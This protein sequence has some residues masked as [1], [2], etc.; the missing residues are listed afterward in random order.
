VLVLLFY[1][2]TLY[3]VAQNKTE[4]N[5]KQHLQFDTHFI[6]GNKFLMLKQPDDALREFKMALSIFPEEAAVNYLISQIYLQK[7]LLLDAELYAEK[8]AKT[9]PINEWYYKLLAEIY[10]QQKKYT[11]A[12]KLYENLFTTDY[13]N[14]AF[15]FDA[16]YLYMLAQNFSP[17]IGLLQ[18]AEKKNGINADISKQIISIY[19][20]QGNTKK[21]ITEANKLVQKFPKSMEYLGQLADLY[22]KAGNEKEAN[23]IYTNILTIEPDNGYALLAM[24]DYYRNSKQFELWYA[25]TLNA[26]KST[27]LDIKSKLRAIVNVMADKELS[28]EQSSKAIDFANAFTQAN[29]DEQTAWMILG[30]IYFEKRDVVNAHIQYEK[31]AEINPSNYSVW[32]QMIICSSELNNHEWIMHDCGRALEIFPTDAALYAYYTF[33]AMQLKQYEKAIDV[34]Q[35][36]IENVMPDTALLIQL[37]I[38]IGDAA[39]YLEKFTT[40]DSAFEAA[41]TLNPNSVYA[42]NNYA[43]FLSLRKV[44]LETALKYSKRALSIEPNNASFLDTYGWV[45]FV[46]KDYINAKEYI[47]KSLQIEP[48]NDEVIEH[49]GDVLYQLGNKEKAVEQWQKAKEK[50]KSSTVLDKKIKDKKWYEE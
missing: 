49:Y 50:G 18:K 29:P 20:A 41:L 43:Y 6:N 40:C 1:T 9:K 37:Y 15:L 26:I 46:N 3:S 28:K 44:K 17:A 24:A 22:L 4:L 13:N 48:N 47:E 39:H 23:K 32:Q 16:T 7:G 45:L 19:L 12:A 31:A 10:R 42:L 25:N 11:N 36:G 2:T 5:E 27:Q 34:A 21:A 30:D 8:A 38:T 33:S 35:K 14:L